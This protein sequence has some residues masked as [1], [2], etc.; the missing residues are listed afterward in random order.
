MS[1]CFLSVHGLEVGVGRHGIEIVFCFE[2]LKDRLA[3][4]SH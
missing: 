3:A 2:G 4:L 1:L